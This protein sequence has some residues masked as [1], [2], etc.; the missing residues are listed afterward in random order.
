MRR[1]LLIGLPLI[2]VLGAGAGGYYLVHLGTPVQRAKAYLVRGQAYEAELLLDKYLRTHPDDPEA[3]YELG[4]VNLAKQNPV[5]AERVFKRARANGYDPKAIILPLGE[6][7]LQ[8]KNRAEDILNDF[9][10]DHAPQ[11]ARAEV[12]TVRA[13]AY[14]EERRYDEAKAAADE[15]AALEPDNLE[16]QLVGARIAMAAGKIDDATARVDKVLAHDPRHAEGLL[17]KGEIAMHHGDATSAL[18]YAQ[19]VLNATPYRLDAKMAVARALAALHRDLDALKLVEDVLKHTPRAVDANY[20][21]LVVGVRQHDYAAADAALDVLSGYMDALPQ[22]YYFLA[23]TKLGRNEPAIAEEAASKYAARN[24]NDPP[25]IKLLAFT[26]LAVHKPQKALDVLRPLVDAGKTDADTLDLTARAQAMMGDMTSAEANLTRA[27]ALQPKNT[28]ILNRLAASKLGLGQSAAAEADLRESLIKAPNQPIAAE[29]LVQTALASG[30]YKG[31]ERAVADLRK[32]VGDT[33]LVGVL[34][35]QVHVAELDLNGAEAQFQDL[36]KRFPDS[37][38]ATFGLIQAEGRLGKAKTAQD[39]LDGWMASH[40]KDRGGLKLQMQA[41]AA[42]GNLPGA[43]TA[44]EAAHAADP[45]DADVTQ[46]LATLYLQAKMPDRAIS[47][48]DRAGAATNP[49]LG[50]LRGVALIRANRN[51]DARKQLNAALDAAP[52]APQPRMALVELDV[53]DKDYDAAR[54]LVQDGLKQSPGNPRYQQALI[55][56]DMKDGGEAAALA[57]AAELQK[58]PKNLPA[59]LML[60]GSIYEMG[61]KQDKA[62]DAYVAAYH[63][64]PSGPT[65][66]AAATSLGRGKRL[67]ERTALL[68]DYLS[69][70]PDDV[71]AL[72]VVSA[73]ALAARRMDEAGKRLQQILALQPNNAVALNNMA[74]VKVATNDLDAAHTLAQRAYYLQPGA[75]TQ[76]TL[77]WVLERQGHIADALPLLGQAATA[78]PSSPILYHYAVS[79]HANGHNEDARAALTRALKDGKTFDEQADAKKLQAE[80]GG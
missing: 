67:A 7:Y 29:T 70:H 54:H 19:Q 57:T 32:A 47:L 12:L 26:E 49:A 79:L 33:E 14:M 45:S 20:L 37:R 15:A 59:A 80:L 23:I 65:A 58:D 31:A 48:L 52:S 63:R 35:A 50:A 5:A 2:G 8:Q 4:M 34:D 27:A 64:Q 3:N 36:L 1:A 73:D 44:A 69:Q 66:I 16:P 72:E 28:D 11:G 77:G 18:K 76:D 62:A 61:G 42:G 53:T 6:A 39:R 24:P 43:I 17:I 9:N 13:S 56:I 10:A 41:Q 78:K 25:A 40:P 30:D 75:E 46:S 38:A 68:N 55:G 74:W 60:P 22:G 21:K 71:L 51:S